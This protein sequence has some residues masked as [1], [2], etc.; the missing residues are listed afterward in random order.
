MCMF[1][2]FGL[3]QATQRKLLPFVHCEA[4][5]GGCSLASSGP[6]GGSRYLQ[7]VWKNWRERL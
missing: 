7:L 2:C 5:G 4:R 1:L 6:W 3:S